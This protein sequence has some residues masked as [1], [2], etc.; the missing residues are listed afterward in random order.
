MALR[1]QSP[2]LICRIHDGLDYGVHVSSQARPRIE[3]C[4]IW[5]NGRHGGVDVRHSAD[6]VLAANT[7]RDHAGTNGFGVVV[8]TSAHG[9]GK[10]LP[11]NVFLRNAGGDVVRR[12]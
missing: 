7:I 11:D 1:L 3:A 6:P 10:V 2:S 12:G 4:E 5:G 8:L 9:G